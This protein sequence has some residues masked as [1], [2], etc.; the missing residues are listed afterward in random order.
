MSVPDVSD[1]YEQLRPELP[2]PEEDVCKCTDQPPIVLQD[3]FS[4]VPLSC[5]RCNLEV[6]PERIGFDE[7]LAGAMAHWRGLHRG[8][9]LLWLDSADYEAWACERLQDPVGRA[10]I[11]G[12]EIAERLN[13]HRR[14]YYWWFEDASVDDFVPLSKCPRCSGALVLR[15][16]CW[17]CEACSIMVHRGD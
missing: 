5:L 3:H 15:F 16:R 17:V 7:Q 11:L 1:P 6:P 12:M 4:S 9:Y 13:V 10:Q 2:T 8:L 14:A